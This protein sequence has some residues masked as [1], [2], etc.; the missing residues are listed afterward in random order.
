M[1]KFCSL[2]LIFAFLGPWASRAAIKSPVDLKMELFSIYKEVHHA[3]FKVH[4]QVL[5]LA[6]KSPLDS[7]EVSGDR[8]LYFAVEA[9]ALIQ[10]NFEMIRAHWAPDL[11]TWHDDFLEAV[12]AQPKQEA[13]RIVLNDTQR[14]LQELGAMS[15]D[16]SEAFPGLVS[17]GSESLLYLY[18]I[19]LDAS[20][21]PVSVTFDLGD[22]KVSFSDARFR[23]AKRFLWNQILG[24]ASLEMFFERDSNEIWR[25][26]QSAPARLMRSV[27]L[28]RQSEVESVIRDVAV[29]SQRLTH[30]SLQRSEIARFIEIDTQ[31]EGVLLSMRVKRPD[32]L[33]RFMILGLGV[34]LDLC[35]V[36]TEN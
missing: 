5:A 33:Q 9:R 30:A 4:E 20:K 36:V 8:N 34:D 1:R 22:R 15:I 14:F 10:K 7:K 23:L 17:S 6:L 31:L 13:W 24:R 21:R 12:I 2:A 25:N 35:R 11:N 3:F 26:F 19:S 29:R 27:G 18:P 32:I 28:D 16:L